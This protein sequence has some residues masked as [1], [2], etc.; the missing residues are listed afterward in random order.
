MGSFDDPFLSDCIPVL[1][2]CL[3]IVC[4]RRRI[5]GTS[6]FS[7]TCEKKEKRVKIKGSGILNTGSPSRKIPTPL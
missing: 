4:A 2:L 6:K 5:E 1:A 7:V 3:C